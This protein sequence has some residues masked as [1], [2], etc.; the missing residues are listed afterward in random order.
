MY[1][2][3]Y[4]HTYIHIHTYIWIKSVHFKFLN[5][6][7]VARKINSQLGMTLGAHFILEQ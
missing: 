7:A 3:P 2:Y 5:I 4:I 1:I 6:M